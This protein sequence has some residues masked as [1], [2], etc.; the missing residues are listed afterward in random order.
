MGKKNNNNK[1]Q[2]KTPNLLDKEDDYFLESVEKAL[3]EI[4]ARYDKDGDGALSIEEL[5]AFAIGCNGQA[6]DQDS[7]ESIQESFDVTDDDKQYLTLK[8]FM[9]M[10]LLQ[11]SAEPEETWKDIKKH[12]YNTD[13][14]LTTTTT[15]PST[16]TTT[17]NTA[18]SSDSSSLVSTSTQINDNNTEDQSSSS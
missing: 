18:S 16:S 6:F 17:T 3:K 4:F 8:G 14:K 15:T 1:Q 5:N 9:E 2:Q 7:I 10:Y 11:S 13:F 12:G